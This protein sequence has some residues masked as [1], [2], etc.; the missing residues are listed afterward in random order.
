MTQQSFNGDKNDDVKFN[1]S[2][3]N[4]LMFFHSVSSGKRNVR[5]TLYTGQN[6]PQYA[7]DEWSHGS[8]QEQR[9]K[10]QMHFL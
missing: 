7:Q 10:E 9:I 2:D 5:C 3:Y 1:K 6:L 8:K 4:A